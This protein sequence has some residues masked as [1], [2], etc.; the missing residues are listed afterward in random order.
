MNRVVI[1]GMGAVTPVGNDLSSFW[2][3]LLSGKN[4]IG[5]LT[6]FDTGQY[7][8][9]LAAEVKG[10]DPLL[11]RIRNRRHRYSGGGTPKIT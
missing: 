2:D 1:T 10:F 5:P 9:K 11:Y 4:G 8:A 6:R 7:K 3:A